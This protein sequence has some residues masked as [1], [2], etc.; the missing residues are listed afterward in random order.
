MAQ[1][2]RIRRINTEVGKDKK[3][4]IE[5]NQDFDLMEILSLKFSQV[6]AYT[7]FCS[8]YGVV[9]GRISVNNGLGVPNARVSIFVPLKNKHVDDPVISAL[10]PY[11]QVTDKD[12]NNYRYNLLPAR[13]QHGGHTPTGTFPDQLDIL[14][15]EA[16]LEVYENYYSFTVKTNDSGDFMIWGVP[17]GTQTMH[18]DLDLSDMGCFSLRPYDFIRQ[19]KGVDNF[20]N[21]YTFKASEDLNSLPQLVSFDKTIEVYPFWGNEDFCDIGISR[22]DFDLSDRG[23]KIQPKAFLIG[24]VYTDTAKNAVNKNCAP[25]QK[26]GRKCDLV[27]KSAKIEAIRFTPQKELISGTTIYAPILEEVDLHEDIPDDGGFVMPLDMN[28]DYLYT[29][30]FGENEITNDPNKGVPTSACYRLRI[31]L[32][33]ND[34]SRARLNADF[35]IPNI[36]EY[37]T[38][39]TIDDRSYAFSTTWTDYPPLALSYDSTIGIFNNTNGEY[40][41]K[42]YFYRF[43]YNKVYT[44]SSF[45][46]NYSLAGNFANINELHPA[47]EEDCGDKLTPPSNFGKKNYTFTLLIADFLM[48]LDRITKT[49]TLVGTN[50]LVKIVDSIAEALGGN[51]TLREFKDQLMINNTTP[52]GLV[53]YPECF[54]CAEDNPILTGFT[55]TYQK[56]TDYCLVATFNVTGSSSN[57][58]LLISNFTP[59]TLSGICTGAT[60]LTSLNDFSTNQ[61]NY[62]GEYTG[63]TII[64]QILPIHSYISGVTISGVTSYYYHDYEKNF[65]VDGQVYTVNVRDKNITISGTTNSANDASGC[66]LYDIPYNDNLI[67]G[68][69]VADNTVTSTTPPT[70]VGRAYVQNA[71]DLNGRPV[72]G[73][74]IYGDSKHQP[75]GYLPYGSDI[76]KGRGVV[77]IRSE[78]WVDFYV[79]PSRRSEFANG[80][81]YVVPGTQST[82]RL[83]GI[84]DEYYRRK[85]VGKL[86]CGGVVNYAYIDNW[87]SGSLYFFQFKAKHVLTKVETAIKYCRD[88]V[89]YVQ[90]QTRFYYRSAKTTDGK[91]FT[92]GKLNRPTTFVD[93]GPR[94][95]FIKEICIDESLDPN[96]AV[97]RSIG[98]TTYQDMGELIGLAINYRM[99]IAGDSGN[100][101]M[102]FQN[103]GFNGNYAFTN[104]LDG[105]ILQLL[106]INNE[107][108]IEGFDLQNPKYIGYNF[109]DLDPVIYKSIYTGSTNLGPNQYGP[110]PLTFELQERTTGSLSLSGYEIRASLNEPEHTDYFNNKIQG[111][112]TESSQYVPFYLWDKKG[113]GFGAYDSELKNDQSWDYTSVQMQPLQGMTYA[114]SITGSPNDATDK[115]VLLPMT[116]DYSGITVT[117][118]TVISNIGAEFDIIDTSGVDHHTLY[119]D[120]YPGFTY[121]Y[122]TSGTQLFP[123]TGILY[124]RYGN[125][126]QW[127]VTPWNNEEF[128]IKRTENYYSGNKQILSTPFQFYFGLTAGKTG[129]DK[130]IDLFGPK[131]AFPPIN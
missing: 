118:N 62:Y 123:V 14:N 84:I 23:V 59:S 120:T 105:D 60:Q 74:A 46:S 106:S 35:L 99:E 30:E 70:G 130:F 101:T 98:A 27:S 79:T 111:R 56:A 15:N 88:L 114:Y 7:S 73:V 81:F 128:I 50:Y 12:Q 57:N 17:L 22:A 2:H 85:R 95:E 61:A 24:G 29:N 44:V 124:V 96:S 26:M 90:G 86:F 9:C 8:D 122:V 19:G 47:E 32:N 55:T 102:F 69:F 18:I 1:Q 13:Q 21:K 112:L 104:V 87:L 68:Y 119:N 65:K 94:D 54:D 121:L 58:D 67:T 4:T 82:G 51:N 72:I 38:G 41:P 115:Y 53:N 6:Q 5:L 113:I 92:P 110:L 52:L 125:A 108:G 10:Y 31:N 64:L 40:Y 93:L 83:L 28:M 37:Q 11:T 43:N 77:D 49:F 129:M 25:R 75:I 100:L 34:L 78:H 42:D 20:K 48:F 33:D 76:T 71:I 131:G 126:P 39:N 97:A 45:H 36:R 109:N 3:V 91:T 117:G 107:V 16:I 103:N 116:H 63:T 127:N 66:Q 89:R 80:V